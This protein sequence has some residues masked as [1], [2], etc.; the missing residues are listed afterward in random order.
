MGLSDNLSFY[1][2]RAMMG[3]LGNVGTLHL[4]VPKQLSHLLITQTEQV[5]LNSLAS[6]VSPSYHL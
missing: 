3:N 2:L 4:S 1:K 5:T 6:K